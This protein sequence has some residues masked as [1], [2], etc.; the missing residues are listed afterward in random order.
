MV[1]AGVVV[2]GSQPRFLSKCGWAEEAVGGKSVVVAA[3]A[4][5]P[6]SQPRF[7]FRC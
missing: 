7:L 4:V 6:T 3:G 1:A 2:P 5:V